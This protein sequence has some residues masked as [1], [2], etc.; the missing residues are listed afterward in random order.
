M[1]AAKTAQTTKYR[2]QVPA[3]LRGGSFNNQYERLISYEII[4]I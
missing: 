1:G 3:A 4:Y 2:T